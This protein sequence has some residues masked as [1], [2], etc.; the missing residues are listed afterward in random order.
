MSHLWERNY[1]SKMESRFWSLPVWMLS[2]VVYLGQWREYLLVANPQFHW[3]PWVSGLLRPLFL[4]FC[5]VSNEFVLFDLTS[6]PL[7]DLFSRDFFLCYNLGWRFVFWHN[8]GWF[9]NLA[10]WKY[11]RSAGLECH[12][13]A[14]NNPFPIA[15]V[16]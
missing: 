12:L 1:W 13:I 5:C 8:L 4:A 7:A 14:Q 16:N 2:R 9:L 10:L 3:E 15:R 11:R 6:K